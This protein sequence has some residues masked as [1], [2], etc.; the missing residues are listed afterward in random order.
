MTSKTRRTLRLIAALAPEPP[1][2]KEYADTPYGR[3]EVWRDEYG[4]PHYTIGKPGRIV[5]P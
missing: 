2:P 3:A 4:T 5:M 1:G